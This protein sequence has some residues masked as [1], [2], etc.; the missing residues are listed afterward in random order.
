MVRGR[1]MPRRRASSRKRFST[2]AAMS[3][4]LRPSST[5]SSSILSSTSVKLITRW[6]SKPLKL[7]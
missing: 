1:R 4:G 5:A 3:C 2:S 6:T 7:K